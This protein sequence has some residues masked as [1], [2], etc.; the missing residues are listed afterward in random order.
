MKAV[1][2]SAITLFFFSSCGI[3]MLSELT[4]YGSSVNDSIK[5]VKQSRQLM[6]ECDFEEKCVTEK[7]E[8]LVQT[9]CQDFEKYQMVN[10]QDC[11]ANFIYFIEKLYL[12][13]KKIL[14][15]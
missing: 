15:K 6:F 1:I 10:F 11:S 3:G 2:C 7:I 12:E 4:A 5:L 8:N 14:N 13:N 9:E